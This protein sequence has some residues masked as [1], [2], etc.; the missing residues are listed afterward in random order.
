[1]DLGAGSC[2]LVAHDLVEVAVRAD[3]VVLECAGV[4]VCGSVQESAVND[5]TRGRQ[6]WPLW[7]NALILH[8]TKAGRDEAARELHAAGPAPS[9]ALVRFDCRRAEPEL[10]DVLTYWLREDGLEAEPPLLGITNGGTLFLDY[11][12]CLGPECQQLLHLFVERLAE[13]TAAG[14]QRP[15]G[16]LIAGAASDLSDHV[17]SGVFL[18]SLHDSLDKARID[19]RSPPSGPDQLPAVERCVRKSS[20]LR[21]WRSHGAKR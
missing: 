4:W 1:M 19:L 21:R 2:S 17:R 18:A 6:G 12:E 8:G 15:V 7:T 11:V 20:R 9:A 13:A 16:R 3:A 10:C 14:Q 5:T